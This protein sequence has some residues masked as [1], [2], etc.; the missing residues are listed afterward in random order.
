MGRRIAVSGNG[1]GRRLASWTEAGESPMRELL[2]SLNLP[3]IISLA[4]VL[5]GTDFFPSDSYVRASMEVLADDRGALSYHLPCRGLKAQIVRLMAL[6]GVTCSEEQVFIT[7]GAQ[8]AVSLL[9]WILLDRGSTVILDE[10]VYD[11]VAAVTRPLEPTLFTVPSSPTEGCDIEAIETL[12]EDG[13]RPRFIYAIPDA[14]NPT[15]ASLPLRHRQRLVELAAAHG[16]PIIEDDPYGLLGYDG[17]FPPPLFALDPESVIYVGTFSKILAPALRLGWIVATPEILKPLSRARQGSDMNVANLTQHTVAN[18]L[19]DIDLPQHLTRVR[20]E[21]AGRLDALVQSVTGHFPEGTVCH[22][23]QGGLFAWLELPKEIDT[24]RLF[25][26]S[27]AKHG[28]AFIPGEAFAMSSQSSVRHCLRLAYGAIASELV[29]EG[30]ERIGRAIQACDWKER[31]GWT[32]SGP[33]YE[34]HD[35]AWGSE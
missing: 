33:G 14:H 11:G 35:P 10:V 31:A 27:V 28:V 13:A 9:S 26:E 7:A 20:S 17:G 6:R 21:Y 34:A 5:P 19:R 4:H 3:G 25:R 15:G 29:R 1:A 12:L 16:V 32:A 23:P 22:R 30:V 24:G 2:A 8:H 18:L